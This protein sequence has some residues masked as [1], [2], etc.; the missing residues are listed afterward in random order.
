MAEQKSYFKRTIIASDVAGVPTVLLA[1]VEV[2]VYD[3][4]DA[5]A[6][7]YD[8]DTPAVT[9][10]NPFTVTNGTA[11]FWALPAYYRVR[12]HD[13]QI[14]PRIADEDYYWD[15]MSTRAG[16]TNADVLESGTVQ[17]NQLS[18]VGQRSLLPLGAILPYAVAAAPAG[19]LLCDGGEYAVATYPALDALITTTFGARTNG[20]G[21]AGTTHFRVPDLRG[22]VP[23]GTDGAAGRLDALDALGNVGG[24]Q[25][26]TLAEGELPVPNIGSASS[27]LVYLRSG[28]PNGTG[29]SLQITVGSGNADYATYSPG[30]SGT[31]HNNMQPYQIVNYI[32]RNGL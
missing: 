25:K 18:V 9:K 12:F 14:P 20:A 13:T 16:G 3:A 8:P 2:T 28:A 10:P 32:I 23:V 30:G 24:A 29:G 31:P 4:A 27:P 19:F 1:G 22:R 11:R 15:A 17:V 26:H 5:I 21:A 7:I 6:T